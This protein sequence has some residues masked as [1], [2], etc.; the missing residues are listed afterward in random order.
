MKKILLLCLLFCHVWSLNADVVVNPSLSKGPI[1]MMNAVN[2]GPVNPGKDQVRGN[3][4]S[5]KDCKIPYARTHDASFSSAYGGEHSVDITAIFPDF[6]KDA[7]SPDSYDFTMTDQYLLTIHEAGTGIFFRLGQKIEHGVKKYGVMPPADFKKW[8][9]IC[10]HVIRHYNEG[11][12]NG[13]KGGNIEYWEIWNEPDLDWASGGWKTNPRT[14]GG[15]QQQFF[16]LY[17]TA[18]KHLKKCFPDLKIG[19]PALAF[20]EKWADE[21]LAYMSAHHVALDFFSWHIYAMYPEDMVLKARHIHQ[22][23]EKYGYAKTE[24]ILN[25][26]NYV[27][28]WTD[29]FLY[30][31]QTMTG[32]KGGAFIAAVINACQSQPVD[33]LMYYD[34]RP[35]TVFNGLFDFVTYAPLEGYYALYAWSKL[36]ALG[37]QVEAT[38]S[39]KDVWV[40]AASDGKGRTSVFVSRYNEDNNVT[41]KKPV[42]VKVNG[43]KTDAEL[44]GHLTDSFHKYTETPLAAKDGIIECLLEPNAFMMIDIR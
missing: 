3:F 34:A 19:G 11:W 8:A 6:S 38:S 31:S 44:T 32:M 4:Q 27:K 23:L 2:N 9:E 18:A 42:K 14:W 17:E 7:N 10:E 24:S 26:W 25:E 1:K 30:T 41:A 20:D 39:E 13:T 29:E 15:T 22:L 33:M 5:Y 12:A 40:T 21:F 16:E 28:G 36:R 37:T 35:G 43:L